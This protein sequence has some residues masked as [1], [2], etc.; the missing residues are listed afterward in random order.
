[1]CCSDIF[2]IQNY[3]SYRYYHATVFAITVFSF[4]EQTENECIVYRS[5]RVKDSSL[6]LRNL[7]HSCR[8]RHEFGFYVGHHSQM[9][10]LTNLSTLTSD[11]SPQRS[12]LSTITSPSSS[13]CSFIENSDKPLCDNM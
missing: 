13:S 4:T 12:R 11:H 2:V 9:N 3:F 7:R 6:S 8:C 1:M 5:S 10:S